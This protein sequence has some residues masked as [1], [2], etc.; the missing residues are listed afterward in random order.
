MIRIDSISPP[1]EPMDMPVGTYTALMG[2]VAAHSAVKP[3]CAYLFSNRAKL[4]RSIR[5]HFLSILQGWVIASR[6]IT[7]LHCH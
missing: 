6:L 4:H 5:R 2:I 1:T 3:H 7:H